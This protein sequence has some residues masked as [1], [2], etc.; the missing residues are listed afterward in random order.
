[1]SR[2]HLSEIKP[3][4]DAWLHDKEKLIHPLLPKSD[5]YSIDSDASIPYCLPKSILSLLN[6]PSEFLPSLTK[7]HGYAASKYW[8]R[9]ASFFH[10]KFNDLESPDCLYW[11]LFQWKGLPGVPK[12][13][14][15][16]IIDKNVLPLNSAVHIH[17]LYWIWKRGRDC[18]KINQ[19][20]TLE[21]LLNEYILD[22]NTF[23][24]DCISF[25]VC[26]SL[27]SLPALSA[28]Q[29][30]C[31]IQPSVQALFLINQSSGSFFKYP[32]ISELINL[33]FNVAVTNP[34]DNQSVFRLVP[35]SI[36]VFQD[37]VIQ[38]SEAQYPLFP[39]ICWCF[40]GITSGLHLSL[41]SI[42][43]AIPTLEHIL[44][45]YV[46][47]W[48]A[49]Y[50]GHLQ[51]V[52][53]DTLNFAESRPP[54]KNHRDT[55]EIIANWDGLGLSQ[56]AEMTL[57][58]LKLAGLTTIRVHPFKGCLDPR[59]KGDQAT[60]TIFHVN[61]DDCVEITLRKLSITPQI[62]ARPNIL[63]F[64]LWELEQ[65]PLAHELGC[66]LVD[67]IL[68]PSE[69]LTKTYKR[70]ESKVKMVGKA[71]S[72]P[73]RDKTIIPIEA[74]KALDFSFIF[75]LVFD[76]GS[77]IE[78]KNPYPA[79]KAFEQLYGGDPEV[80]L[81]IKASPPPANHWGDP[82]D[83]YNRIKAIANRYENIIFIERRIQDEEIYGLVYGSD[84]IL[85][86]HRAEGFGYLMSYAMLARKQLIATDYSG[87]A[88]EIRST[89]LP[90]LPLQYTLQSPIA[91]KFFHEMTGAMWANVHLS[92]LKKRMK[93][94]RS[95]QCQWPKII[96]SRCQE[97]QKFD[98][99][100]SAQ[101]YSA[102]LLQAL[103]Q[104]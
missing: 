63:G 50:P 51:L 64:F 74:R 97:Y 24:N 70:Y 2:V 5:R 52:S 3:V 39:F 60:K 19:L 85:S 99:Y 54:E 36:R 48:C 1:M 72:L 100:Y 7:Y 102:S 34:T 28:H 84:A 11:F 27:Y 81:I 93:Q 69:F 80:C 6:S 47:T 56:N 33:I 61:A 87:I 16:L 37:L 88:S 22:K 83:Q 90:W 4:I 82:F 92:D 59:A 49:R 103:H 41:S 95:Q 32:R 26:P 78:R 14:S 18:K 71:I 76:S 89:D 101:R 67:T 43:Q 31:G 77:G 20:N 21:Q 10:Q 58:A 30:I 25:N 68:V 98:D 104:P 23:L 66:Y 8:Q 13:I 46:H 17:P 40:H 9:T 12:Q 94:A 15:K 53:I 91:G 57:Q 62:Q 38:I 73:S 42:I 75:L 44:E 55:V 86:S 79:I 96:Q 29:S 45:W 35:E 65:I